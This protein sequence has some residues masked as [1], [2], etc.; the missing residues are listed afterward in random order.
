MDNA[1]SSS[2][3]PQGAAAVAAAAAAAAAAEPAKPQA[4]KHRTHHAAHAAPTP[5]QMTPLVNLPA[6][7]CEAVASCLPPIDRLAVCATSK[8]V[9]AR[10]VITVD[11]L[12]LGPRRLISWSG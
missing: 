3:T 2:T 12:P 11:F 9:E 10:F 6:L 7:L 1:A 5:L 8:A 4:P